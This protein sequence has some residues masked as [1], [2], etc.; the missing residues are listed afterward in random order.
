ML[1]DEQAH[2]IAD[3]ITSRVTNGD[4]DKAHEIAFRAAKQAAVVMSGYHSDLEVAIGEHAF[5]AGFRAA[6]GDEGSP[7]DP[8]Y[9]EERAWSAYTPPE[10]L[11]GGGVAF[12][13]GS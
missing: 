2:R 1:T 9:R 3:D 6:V 5:R 7:Q 11:T 8:T 4:R 13:E 12:S 10:H